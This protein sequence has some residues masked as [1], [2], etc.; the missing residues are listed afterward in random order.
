MDY[1]T[2]KSEINSGLPVGIGCEIFTKNAL[3]RSWLFGLLA[4]HREHVNE[5]ILENK[6]RFKILEQQPA[7]PKECSSLRLTLDTK[8]DFIFLERVARLLE[9]RRMVISVKNICKLRQE[10]LL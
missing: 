4:H 10:G 9:E 6:N 8:E 7:F 2:N 5:Y 1:S 3:E